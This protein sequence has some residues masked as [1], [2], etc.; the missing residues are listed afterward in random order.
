MSDKT[1]PAKLRILPSNH[2]W[3]S[4]SKRGALLGALPDGASIV[5]TIAEARVGLLLVDDAAGVRAGLA[6]HAVA[7]GSLEVFWVL[8]PKG[9][10]ADINRD[11][12]WPILLEHGFRPIHQI[13]VDEVWSALRFRLLQPGETGFGG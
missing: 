13:A 1:V 2:V 10:R 7:L 4:D 8:Y 6:A 11:S 9:G 3:I 5:A 12:L